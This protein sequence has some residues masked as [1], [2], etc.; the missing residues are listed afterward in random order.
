MGTPGSVGQEAWEGR[1]DESQVSMIET[2]LS[3]LM[4]A[5]GYESAAGLWED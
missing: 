4:S 3:D 5:F 1:L 2:E